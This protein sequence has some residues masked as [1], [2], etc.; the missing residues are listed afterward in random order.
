M[1]GRIFPLSFLCIAGIGKCVEFH[2]LI[3]RLVPLFVLCTVV[4]IN[5]NI[6]DWS[7]FLQNSHYV[8]FFLRYIFL[9][10]SQWY[11]YRRAIPG[12]SNHLFILNPTMC[13]WTNPQCKV[14]VCLSHSVFEQIAVGHFCTTGNCFILLTFILLLFDV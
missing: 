6:I 4:G 3:Q 10:M 13:T 12:W 9:N 1:S 14:S 7:A 8:Y 5:M 11:H 2:R